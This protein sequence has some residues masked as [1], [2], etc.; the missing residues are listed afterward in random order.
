[1]LRYMLDTDFCIDV[2]RDRPAEL[3]G[4][5]DAEADALCI[6][7]VTLAELLHGA[8]KSGR[9]IDNRH[10]V[11]RFVARLA[12]LSFDAEAADHSA[13]IRATLERRGNPIG[14]YDVL[15]AGHARSRG[16]VVITGN[17]GEFGRVEGLRAENW[18]TN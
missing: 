9:P 15:I 5:F 6:S 1:M 13:D 4:R 10:E 8:A 18:R 2:L 16:L 11:E 17:T 12:V 3:R 7:T 14:A